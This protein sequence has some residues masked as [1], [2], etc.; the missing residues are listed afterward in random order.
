MESYG[1]KI[2]EYR[3]YKGLNQEEAANALGITRPTYN[4]IETDKRSIT[5]EE[6]QKLCKKLDLTLEQ[7]L[8]SSAQVEIYEGKMVRYKQIILNCLQH[9]AISIDSKVSQGKLAGLVYLCDFAAYR[10]NGHS[11]SGLAYRHSEYGLI[12]DAYYRMIGKLYDEGAINIELSG[13]AILIQANEPSA[14]KSTLSEEEV[15]LIE[16]ECKPWKDK[17][18]QDVVSFVQEQSPWKDYTDGQI[19]P[20]VAALK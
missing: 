15:R 17:S 11:L 1:Q 14:P 5:L 19:V 8:F 2:K 6:L 10:K 12:V 4:A 18:T 20:Y 16:N 7:F 3:E 9:G 13:R